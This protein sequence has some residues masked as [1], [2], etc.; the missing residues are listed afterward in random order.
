[1]PVENTSL[2]PVFD[3]SSSVLAAWMDPVAGVPDDPWTAPPDNRRAELERLGDRIAELS[4]RIQA[5]TYELLVLIRRV[6]RAQR[7]GKLHLLRPLAELAYR[8]RAG[9]GPRACAGGARA[10]ELAEAERRHAARRR[11]LLEG[12]GGHAGG[13]AGNRAGAARR[14]AVRHGSACGADLC[15]AGDGLTG[16]L[17]RR[18]TGGG[19]RRGRCAPGWTKTGWWWYAGG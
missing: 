9:C 12:A 15:A 6:R 1:M 14:G 3:T 8:T 2:A 16:L 7:L 11:L 13:H 4:A 5:A 17:S 10:W 19:T 18:R